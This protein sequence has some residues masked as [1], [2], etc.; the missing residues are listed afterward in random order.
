MKKLLF[1]LCLVSSLFMISCGDDGESPTITI[2]SPQNGATVAPGETLTI[3]GTA[4]DDID[5]VSVRFLSSAINLD[6]LLNGTDFPDVTGG[7]FSVDIN[8]DAASVEGMYTIEVI[9]TDNDQNT[10]TEE[11]E[12]EVKM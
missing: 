3:V 11:L 6:G 12:I 9:A 1:S 5:L 8:F 4:T 2:T 10:T 7:S